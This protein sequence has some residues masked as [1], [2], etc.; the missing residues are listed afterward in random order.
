MGG[1]EPPASLRTEM[2]WFL[3][4]NT[5]QVDAVRLP[6]FPGCPLCFSRL[7][8]VRRCGHQSHYLRGMR[9]AYTMYSIKR[10]V[11]PEAGSSFCLYK[12]YYPF[13]S[14]N[15]E[16]FVARFSHTHLI[17]KQLFPYQDI[18]SGPSTAIA[19]RDI[20]YLKF[21]LPWLKSAGTVPRQ[22][23]KE[24]YSVMHGA[25]LLLLPCKDLEE[26]LIIP[27]HRFQERPLPFFVSGC[28]SLL[29]RRDLNP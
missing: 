21:H 20:R 10:P 1:S 12:F 3:L 22:S 5:C 17:W 14:R 24:N 9:K 19:L 25:P 4:P 18:Y 16:S 13:Q 27:T 26:S 8:P 7:L 11:I 15:I 23:T 2:I 28:I 29:R 6:V